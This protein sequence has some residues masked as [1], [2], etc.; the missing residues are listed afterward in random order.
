MSEVLE[1]YDKPCAN[2]LLTP[3][4]IV[5]PRRA[6]QILNETHD[7]KFIC[8]KASMAGEEVCCRT[9]YDT[10]GERNLLIRLARMLGRVR[11]VPIP[12]N[13][14]LPSWMDSHTGSSET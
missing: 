4:R 10:F 3:D 13:K 9:F 7:S 1:V 12:D 2:C 5:S 14:K 6:K 8:H 11:F